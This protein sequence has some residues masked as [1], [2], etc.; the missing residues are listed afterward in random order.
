MGIRVL[1]SH[2]GD[3]DILRLTRTPLALLEGGSPVPGQSLCP[4]PGRLPPMGGPPPLHRLVTSY[5]AV[6]SWR[7]TV[8]SPCTGD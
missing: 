6:R 4:L 3:A 1:S 5:Y 7:S 8:K 2:Y